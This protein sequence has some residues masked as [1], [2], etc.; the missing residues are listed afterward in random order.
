MSVNMMAAS[1]LC[2]A[3]ALTAQQIVCVRTQPRYAKHCVA[4]ARRRSCADSFQLVVGKAHCAQKCIPA[5][6]PVQILVDRVA[7]DGHQTCVAL[8]SCALQPFECLILLSTI[9]VYSADLAGGYV[10]VVLDQI[11]ERC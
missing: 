3:S 7:A 6:V 9:G 2:D 4:S 8:P 10:G 5:R 11:G 1:F